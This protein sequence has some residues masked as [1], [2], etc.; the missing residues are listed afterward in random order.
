MPKVKVTAYNKTTSKG[1]RVHVRAQ[2][3]NP[4]KPKAPKTNKKNN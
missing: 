4:P 3:R 1:N 2:N